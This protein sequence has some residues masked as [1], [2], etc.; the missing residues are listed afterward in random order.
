MA[1]QCVCDTGLTRCGGTCIDTSSDN[2][3]CGGCNQACAGTCDSS[4]CVVTLAVGLVYGS[5]IAVDATSVYF[6]DIGMGA[7][8]VSPVGSVSKVPLRGG[9]VT[10]LASGQVDPEAI[11]VSGPYVYWTTRTP[12]NVTSSNLITRATLDGA[13]PFGLVTGA[14]VPVDLAVD[15]SHVFWVDFELGLMRVPLGGGTP[16]TLTT[17]QMFLVNVAIDAH[18]I[19]CAARNGDGNG[20]T[21]MG[22]IVKVPI[23][24][25]IPTM[26]ARGQL[27]PAGIAVDATHAYWTTGTGGTV[28]SAPLAGGPA[29][30]LAQVGNGNLAGIA[31]DSSSVYFTDIGGTRTVFKV[32]LAGGT[33]TPIAT[34]QNSP[35][36]IVVDQTSAY[37]VTVDSVVKVTPK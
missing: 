8:I 2:A 36:R 34:G 21:P 7:G 27:G 6:T 17:Q 15:G 28:M 35:M 18:D 11:A 22:V 13:N 33:A 20:I 4:R 10:T 30:M 37:W 16:S 14:G 23:A 19:Y 29:T 25:G 12:N 3:N 31:V 32:P 26:L 9:A 24:G 1:S 5:G